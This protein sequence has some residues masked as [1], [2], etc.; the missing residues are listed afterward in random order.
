M[1][2]LTR[3]H[4]PFLKWAGGKFRLL[5]R[6][7]ATLP[8]GNRFIEPFVGSGALFLNTDY[9]RYLLADNNPDLINL[10]QTLTR[11]GGEF[12]DYASRLFNADNN[13]EAAYYR[14]RERFNALESGREKSALFLYLNRHG[15]NGLCRYNLKGIFN[16]PYGRYKKPY[17]PA[18]EMAHFARKARRATFACLDFNT[19]LARARRHNVVY[20]DPPYVPWSITANFTSYSQKAFSLDMQTRLAVQ[21]QRLAERGVPVIISNHDTPFT[22]EIYR[23][24]RLQAF[25]VQRFISCNGQSRDQAGE[26]LAAFL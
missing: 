6:I 8:E 23:N 18:D 15:Y 19:T 7:L 14:L 3:L 5:P 11:E 21:A 20:C 4:R 25:R 22:R 2:R 16:V 26:L 10:Y 9:E 24:A 13:Q 17:F 1:T 12:I